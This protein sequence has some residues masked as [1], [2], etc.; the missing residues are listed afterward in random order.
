ML[1][2]GKLLGTI[3][4][5]KENRLLSIE[6]AVGII[7]KMFQVGIYLVKLTVWVIPVKTPPKRWMA[8]GLKRGVSVNVLPRL[9]GNGIK[10][11]GSSGFVAAISIVLIFGL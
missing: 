6:S 5:Q 4:L 11:E 10:S 1:Y 2:I 7:F 9:L 8:C 3:A